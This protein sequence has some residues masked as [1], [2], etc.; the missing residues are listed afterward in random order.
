M[1]FRFVYRIPAHVAEIDR[2]RIPHGWTR[3]DLGPPNAG[4]LQ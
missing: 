3:R 2:A 4:T 1:R